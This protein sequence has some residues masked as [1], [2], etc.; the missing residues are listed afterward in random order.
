VRL[1]DDRDD[2][3]GAADEGERAGALVE[4]EPH[5]HGA[6]HDLE[7]RD[8]PH[9]RRG[10][11]PRAHGEQR[12]PEPDL[13]DAERREPA[14]VAAADLARTGEG[15]EGGDEDH[16]GEARGRRHRHVVA[17]AGDHD[18]QPERQRRDE[19]EAVTRK[20]A[21][22]RRPEHQRDAH[23]RERHRRDRA[24]CD[25][26]AERHPGQQGREHGGDGHDEQHAGDA[27]VVERGYEAPGRGRDAERHGQARDTDRPERLH[28]SPALCDRDVGEQRGAGERRAARYLSG[29]VERELALEDAGGRPRDRGER[30]IDLSAAL[31]PRPLERHRRRRHVVK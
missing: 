18:H 1:D 12:K 29:C 21:L 25:R 7:Q 9:L 8:Q 31:A 14:D 5:P 13:A 30:H 23:E 24:P 19:R 2:H 27:G 10:Y 20:A 11:E 4:R 22:A 16:L 3:N 26:L 6:Q 15:S 17:P 28:H